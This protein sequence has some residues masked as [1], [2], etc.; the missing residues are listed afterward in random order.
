MPFALAANLGSDGGVDEVA[1][2]VIDECIRHGSGVCFA[3]VC[4]FCDSADKIV[5]VTETVTC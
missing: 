4:V 5:T 2:E 3:C 1:D